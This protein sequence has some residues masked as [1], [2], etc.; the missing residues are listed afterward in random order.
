MG[1]K[2]P[3]DSHSVITSQTYEPLCHTDQTI[4]LSRVEHSKQ[5]DPY[6]QHDLDELK[7]M[8]QKIKVNKTELGLQTWIST[9]GY[10]ALLKLQHHHLDLV[11]EH[12][13]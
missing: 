12:F 11:S 6:W 10:M 8:W 2:L 13:W 9:V 3:L 4:A 7:S 1:F 5:A